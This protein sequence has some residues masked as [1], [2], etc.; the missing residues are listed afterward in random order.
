M[1]IQ[2][3][4]CEGASFRGR[5]YPAMPDDTAVNCAKMAELI[6][7]PFGLWTRMGP[8]KHV[9]HGSAPPGEYN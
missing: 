6:E 1:G 7:M 4:S 2:I 3:T 5:K 8:R 9:L